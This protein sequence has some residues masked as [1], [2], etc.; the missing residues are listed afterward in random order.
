MK[1]QKKT[2]HGPIVTTLEEGQPYVDLATYEAVPVLVGKEPMIG[3]TV[4]YY[5]RVPLKW[6]K[7]DPNG[8]P[9]PR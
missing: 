4:R 7:P 2:V 6:M 8:K 5:T 3:Q 1:P 9:V